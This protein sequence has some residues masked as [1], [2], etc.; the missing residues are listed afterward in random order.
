MLAFKFSYADVNANAKKQID[1]LMHDLV[2]YV[3]NKDK[4]KKN[5]SYK[6]QL[7]KYLNLD[8]MAKSYFRKILENC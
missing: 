1:N 5:F 6:K 4:S 2:T 3:E 7:I 8:F